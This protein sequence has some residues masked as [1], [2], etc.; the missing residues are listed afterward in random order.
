M[1]SASMAPKR[2]PAVLAVVAGLGEP[3]D[4]RGE[5]RDVPD[6]RHGAVLRMQRQRHPVLL[7]Q[8]VDRR[9]PGGVDPVLGD[10]VAAGLGDHRGVVRVEQQVELRL[11]EIVLVRRRTAAAVTRSAS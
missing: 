10:A 11:V 2:L 5:R 1:R 3:V 7:G 9:A 6:H 4:H 8:P